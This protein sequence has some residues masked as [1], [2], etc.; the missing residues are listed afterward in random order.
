MD[1][2][3]KN[4]SIILPVVGMLA[5]FPGAVMHMFALGEATRLASDWVYLSTPLLLIGL[6]S[7]IGLLRIKLGTAGLGVG[8]VMSVV[9]LGVLGFNLQRTINERVRWQTSSMQL[10]Q[11][12]SFCNGQIKPNPTALPFTE[13]GTNPA[14][15]FRVGESGPSV[16]D[17]ALNRFEPA[18][19]QIEKAAVVVCVSEK[20][21]PVETCTGYIGGGVVDRQR[22]DLTFQA[23]SIKSGQKVFEKRYEGEAP[24]ACGNTEKFYGKSL[25]LTI[26]GEPA[27]PSLVAELGPLL[28]H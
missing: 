11:T 8:A 7:F 28:A 26:S 5:L 27:K 18:D 13:D 24:R 22:V 17:D 21:V 20:R 3:R 10:S 19:Y 14:V 16:Y 2:R 6:A 9:G 15:F 23:F 25:H 4:Q 1:S 12:T